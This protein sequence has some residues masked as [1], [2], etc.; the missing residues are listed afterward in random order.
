MHWV[1]FLWHVMVPNPCEHIPRKSFSTGKKSWM[2][3]DLG[4]IGWNCADLIILDDHP[5]KLEVSSTS[6]QLHRR[7]TSFSQDVTFEIHIWQLLWRLQCSDAK[8]MLGL[9][10]KLESEMQIFEYMDPSP[11]P[12]KKH[13]RCYCTSPLKNHPKTSHDFMIWSSP[14]CWTPKYMA[15]FNHWTRQA[16]EVP[17]RSEI[18]ATPRL[19]IFVRQA[20]GLNG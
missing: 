9:F 4:A 16:F 13:L 14:N 6:V 20:Q 10:Q 1:T 17:E 11:T 8:S 15:S 12:Q 18:C 2:V 19:F 5:N 7:F 3:M